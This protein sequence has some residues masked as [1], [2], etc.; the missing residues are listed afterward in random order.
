MFRNRIAEP[1]V[2]TAPNDEALEKSDISM[3]SHEG[4]EMDFILSG[5]LRVRIG[6]HEEIMH[7]G[8]TIYYDSGISHGMVAVNGAPC[9]FLAIVMS[10]Q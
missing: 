7:E 8:D 3:N 1:F 2:V 9:R 5:S 6:E 4:Q 10:R